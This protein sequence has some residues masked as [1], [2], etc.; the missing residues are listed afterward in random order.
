[1]LLLKTRFN[2]YFANKLFQLKCNKVK[3]VS[4]AAATLKLVSGSLRLDAVV[5]DRIVERFVLARD[6]FDDFVGTAAAEKGGN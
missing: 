5:K 3:E 2:F 4:G 1:M 6:D